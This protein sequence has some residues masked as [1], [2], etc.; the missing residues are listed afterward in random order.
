M[1]GEGKNY[2]KKKGRTPKRPPPPKYQKKTNKK[3]NKT[4]NERRKK[5][6]DLRWWLL[7]SEVGDGYPRAA[8]FGRSFVR[9]FVHS[10]IHSFIHRGRG[11]KGGRDG[12]RFILFLFVVS[13]FFYIHFFLP[14]IELFSSVFF[15]RSFCRWPLRLAP[16]AQFKKKMLFWEL[17]VK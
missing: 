14:P 17:K 1:S 2:K 5:R 12:L 10:F 15:L 3:T 7:V 6:R 16:T 8:A 4:K 9:S 13:F 11:G